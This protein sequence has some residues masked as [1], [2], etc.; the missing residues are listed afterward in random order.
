[1]F[2]RETTAPVVPLPPAETLYSALEELGRAQREASAR[3]ARRLDWPRA[4]VGVIRLLSL[5]G[6]VQLTDVAAKLRVDVSVASRQVGQLVDAGYVR[7]TVD[8]DDRR[9]RVLELTD[10]GHDLVEQ[11]KAQS[12]TLFAEVFDGWTDEDLT[13]AADYIRGVAAAI[14]THRHLGH[15]DEEGTH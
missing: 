14:T 12:A 9:A 5:C 10:E 7:R 8:A 13:R 15:E 2:I 1:M 6:P 3:I 11:L 4:G